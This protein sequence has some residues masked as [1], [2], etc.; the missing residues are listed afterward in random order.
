MRSPGASWGVPEAS[1]A[2]LASLGSALGASWGRLGPSWGVFGRAG[3]VRGNRVAFGLGI[4]GRFE[5]VLGASW[6]PTWPQVG[7]QT[8]PKWRKIKA[9]IDQNF[10][11]S[12]DRFWGGFWGIWGAKMEPCW[13]PNGAQDGSYVENTEN[14]NILKN[15]RISMNFWGSGC[16]N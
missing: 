11:A 15:N 3:R 12:W 2:V 10:D 4:L 16:P 8:K 6:W 5:G 7:S 14:Q 1:W 13:H 9:K